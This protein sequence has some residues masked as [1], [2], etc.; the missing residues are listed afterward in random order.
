[1]RWIA[2]SPYDADLLLVG[3]KQGGLIRCR[4]DDDKTWQEQQTRAPNLTCAPSYGSR[5]V[6]GKTYK[7]RRKTIHSSG[8]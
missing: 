1:M 8:H 5:R 2:P 4:R 7:E 3:I 6:A